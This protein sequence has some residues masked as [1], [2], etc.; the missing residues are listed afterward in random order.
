MT[1]QSVATTGP[2]VMGWSGHF[3]G[4]GIATASPPLV[5]GNS[6]R[7]LVNRP[8]LPDPDPVAAA[9]ETPAS[10]ALPTPTPLPSD[11]A[12]NRFVREMANCYQQNGQVATLEEVEADIIHDVPL[13]VEHL[14]RLCADNLCEEQEPWHQISGR[15]GWN[16]P[17][18]RRA[19][20]PTT[21]IGRISGV[22]APQS[23]F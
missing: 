18:R 19:I 17:H 9:A 21:P 12:F 4:G 10:T 14:M 2:P 13:A 8:D 5:G 20:A 6:L 15:V 1:V 3:L 23:D 7:N 16:A 22:L 11:Y